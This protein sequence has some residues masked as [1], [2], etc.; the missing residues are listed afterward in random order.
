ML[1]GIIKNEISESI[2]M[3]SNNNHTNCAAE[4]S[5]HKTMLLLEDERSNLAAQVREALG[6]LASAL[7]ELNQPLTGILGNAQA[8]QHFLKRQIPDLEETQN[9]L[10]DIVVDVKRASSVVKRIR[11]I[12]K[13]DTFSFEPADVNAAIMEIIKVSSLQGNSHEQ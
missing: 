4:L 11:N 5:G 12:L 13:R 7:H 2:S 1:A 10:D 6:E 9:I 3:S 8:A